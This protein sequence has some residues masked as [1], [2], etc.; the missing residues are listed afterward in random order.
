MR[1]A[2]GTYDRDKQRMNGPRLV[3][4]EEEA[5]SSGLI[6]RVRGFDRAPL[7]SPIYYFSSP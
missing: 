7:F 3:L 5:A 2:A 1:P 6:K 4:V